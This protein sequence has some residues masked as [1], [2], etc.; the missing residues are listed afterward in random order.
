MNKNLPD[1]IATVEMPSVKPP[2]GGEINDFALAVWEWVEDMGWHNKK[3]LEY[4]AL[5][6]SEVGEAVNECREEK[7][8]KELGIELA[9]IVIR[10]FDFAE[11]MDIDIGKEMTNKMYINLQRGTRGRAK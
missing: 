2:S 8:T 9:D 6:A 11:E 10:V 5:I 1:V 4:L 3:P 7:T